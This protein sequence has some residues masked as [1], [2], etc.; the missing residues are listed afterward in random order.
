MKS[1]KTNHGVKTIFYWVLAVNFFY[2]L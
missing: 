1:S 2:D